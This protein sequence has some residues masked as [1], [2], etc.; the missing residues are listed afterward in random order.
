MQSEKIRRQNLGI[1]SIQFYYANMINRGELR[2][3]QQFSRRNPVRT[4]LHLFGFNSA[5]A[6]AEWMAIHRESDKKARDIF[7]FM[8]SLY[9]IECQQSG[10]TASEIPIPL[11]V[12]PGS[13]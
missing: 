11:S 7:R 4:S 5:Y 13:C 6:F 1:L 10:E 12:C 3:V 9:E 2:S 8:R